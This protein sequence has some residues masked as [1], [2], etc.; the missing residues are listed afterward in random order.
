MKINIALPLIF[1]LALAVAACENDSAQSAKIGTVD[2][3]RLM[4]ESAAGK[5]GIKFIEAQQTEMQKSL[6]EIQDKLEKNPQDAEAMQELQRLYASSQQRIQA[7]GQNIA[8]QILDLIQRVM[9]EFR[10]KNNYAVL[11]GT[12]ALASYDP[13]LD[14]TNALLSEVNKEKIDFK[15]LPRG[16]ASAIQPPA[17]ITPPSTNG[18]R[19]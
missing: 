3:N 10:K 6:D 14:V 16:A 8:S 15:P 13:A 5:E 4:R 11:I 18:T 17:A 12:D 7:E 19:Q 1:I 2:L 9:N